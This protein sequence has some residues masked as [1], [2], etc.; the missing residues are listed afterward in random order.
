MKRTKITKGR[1]FL[2]T[3]LAIALLVPAGTASG[4][5]AADVT[6]NS[7]PMGKIALQLNPLGFLQFGPIV[8]VEFN[9]ASSTFFTTQF[10]YQALGLLYQAVASEGFE[11]EV[12]FGS[13]AVGAGI[14]HFF[15]NSRSPHRLYIGLVTEYGW[16]GTRGSVGTYQEWEGRN[17]QINV[18]SNFG[19]RLR[20]RSNFFIN[21]GAM[22]GASIEIK[23]DWWRINN[24][25]TVFKG[26]LPVLIIG[27][28]EVAFGWEW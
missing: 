17:A 14:K 13:M 16:G 23:D 10:R 7:K 3:F 19:Y 18:L 20:F 11:N 5:A 24:P 21:L 8:G 12:T 4:Q 22:A 6:S 9:I 2:L 1:I 25:N 26:D 15:N 27:M 28:L